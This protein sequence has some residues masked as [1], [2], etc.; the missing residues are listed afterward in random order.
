MD[1][2]YINDN[3]KTGN[4]NLADHWE[5]NWKKETLHPK[6][7]D[8]QIVVNRLANVDEVIINKDGETLRVYEDSEG[9]RLDLV[10]SELI[11]IL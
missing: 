3:P 11:E 5:E 9:L 2:I 8:F 10:Q 6:V 1:I 7:K 4:C